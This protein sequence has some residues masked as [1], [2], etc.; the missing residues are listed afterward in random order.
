MKSKAPCIMAD[1]RDRASKAQDES[2]KIY[3]AER[4]CTVNQIGP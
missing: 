4:K 1:F 2:G 3:S